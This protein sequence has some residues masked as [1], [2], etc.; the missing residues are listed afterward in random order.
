V[1][2][3]SNLVVSEKTEAVLLAV[4]SLSAKSLSRLL[5]MVEECLSATPSADLGSSIW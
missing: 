4:W 5:V 2:P 3:T 1:L